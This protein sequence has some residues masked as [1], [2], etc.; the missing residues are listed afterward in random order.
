MTSGNIT[1]GVN[2]KTTTQTESSL[3]AGN[4]LQ[5]SITS[6]FLSMVVAFPDRRA[7]SAPTGVMTY[8]ELE[9]ASGRVH[10]FLRDEC[11]SRSEPIAVILPQ[12]ALAVT[13]ILG[14]LRAGKYY[15]PIDP[16]ARIDWARR[17]LDQVT[18]RVILTDAQNARWARSV[19]PYGTW[20]HAVDHFLAPADSGTGDAGLVP[21]DVDTAPVAT[22]NLAFA[23]KPASVTVPDMPHDALAYVYFT[24]GTTGSPNGV[25]DNHRNVLHN[26]MRYTEALSISPDDRLTLLQPIGFSGSVSS[27]FG[28]LLNGAC[29]C[30][31]DAQEQTPATLS[32][33]ISE[34]SV[35]IYHSVPSIFRSITGGFEAYPSVRVVRLEGDRA[36]LR[37]VDRFRKC[38]SRGTILAN[39]LGMT[40]AGI[41]SQFFVNHETEVDGDVLPVGTPSLD[42]RVEVVGD[43]DQPVSPGEVGEIR[44]S[45]RYLAKGYWNQPRLTADR[46]I[47]SASGDGT[48]K[49]KSGDLGRF[50]PDG[51]L[52]HLGRVDNRFKI[53]G[54]W[55]E[56]AMIEEAL[57]RIPEIL[58]AAVVR[59]PRAIPELPG[60]EGV[61]GFEQPVAG[62]PSIDLEITASSGDGHVGSR[63]IAT[64]TDLRMYDPDFDQLVAYIVTHDRQAS[65][66]SRI[67]R[68]LRA[69][70]PGY[71]IPAR[72]VSV[73]H[74]PVTASGKVDRPS[75]PIPDRARP[76]L[77]SEVVSPT[78]SLQLRLVEIW[79]ELLQVDG[80]GIRDDF[81]DLGG[82]SLLVLEML[83]RI[84]RHLGRRLP[85]D[86]LLRS[87]T[88]ED[89]A[90]ALIAGESELREPVVALQTEG[91]GMPLFFFH[92]DYVSGGFYALE[93]ARR[94]GADRPVY[95]VRPCGLDG[96]P[97][98]ASYASMAER[99]VAEI[100][101]VQPRGPY[102]L[103]G[104]CNGGLVA[105]ESAR[106][107]ERRGE[108]V[109]LVL[110]IDSSAANLRFERLARWIGRL[111]ILGLGDR[112]REW[113]FGK[114]RAVVIV[115]SETGL[116]RALG[117]VLSRLWRKLKVAVLHA[118]P[119]VEPT[120]EPESVE[121]PS[122]VAG[123]WS[124]YRGAYQRIDHRYLPRPYNHRAVLLWPEQKRAE[125]NEEAESYWMRVCPQIDVRPTPG[126]VL[127]CHTRYVGE[128]ATAMRRAIDE[129]L[130]EPTSVESNSTEAATA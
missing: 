61:R 121:M 57:V 123:H 85:A 107:L 98:P 129:H 65:N 20:V 10:S 100:M 33:W 128:L 130:N 8:H 32:R 25:I 30:P 79:S 31:I 28:A 84:E 96:E 118:Q 46:F 124:R 101:R 83:D 78:G 22:A 114:M 49:Y 39:G 26:I 70:L 103:G 44:I 5:G 38:F 12:G 54:Q 93:L 13:A 73:E 80:L 105:Y 69:H 110:M 9:V 64:W 4:F 18:P 104:L 15:V 92:G 43:D 62:A 81:F 6:H 11:G 21:R 99:H 14:V 89:L 45:S 87:A 119:E 127:S 115:S 116:V 52:E 34:Q 72:F 60:K 77:D 55:V 112:A 86:T 75:L 2:P 51:L 102:L 117:V 71:A 1:A 56:P 113:M 42:I 27:M 36:S 66:V 122:T 125:T 19:A 48:R 29:L 108:R 67:R 17:V 3:K 109:A 47:A 23:Q 97:V 37:D 120:T 82:D 41:V 95:G 106:L 94:F 59:F 111:R 50:R 76:Q 53:R 58:E 63:P 88:I 68:T 16:A 24:S 7:V 126:D 74:L 91:G 40:E 90:D 35:T